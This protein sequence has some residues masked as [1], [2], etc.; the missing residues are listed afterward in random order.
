MLRRD[1]TNSTKEGTD[2]SEGQPVL[3]KFVW[4]DLMTSDVDQAISFYT[5]LFGW[6]INEADMGP[7][8]KY[9]MI[10]AAG[11]DHGGFMPL[12]AGHGAPSH[13]VSYCT[14]ADVDAALAAAERLGGKTHVPGT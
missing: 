6:T 1:E 8:G 11:T 14:V 13:W 9:R 10:H 7:G 12:E 5:D 4:H 3:G 2:M